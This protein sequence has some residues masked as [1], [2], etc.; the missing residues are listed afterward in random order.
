MRPIAWRYDDAYHCP[1]CADLWFRRQPHSS[2]PYYE[3]V[4]EY[5]QLPRPLFDW[6]PESECDALVCTT[7][8]EILRTVHECGGRAD[9]CSVPEYL[10]ARGQM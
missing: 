4:D 9:R 6:H 8:G 1:E 2:W 3:I 10:L 7:C 5:G